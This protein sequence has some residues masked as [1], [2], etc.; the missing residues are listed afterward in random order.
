MS[1]CFA[2][3]AI[4]FLLPFLIFCICCVLVASEQISGQNSLSVKSGRSPL[5][6][7]QE[8]DQVCIS[9]MKLVVVGF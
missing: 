3:G 7:L 8:N 4:I 9:A 1:K 5:Q 6:T 2:F